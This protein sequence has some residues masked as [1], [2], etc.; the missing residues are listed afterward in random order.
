MATRD[1]DGTACSQCASDTTERL[2]ISNKA[3]A[4]GQKLHLS[5]GAQVVKDTASDVGSSVK[6]AVG[7]A[8]D[9]TTVTIPGVS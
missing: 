9:G 2:G 1:V 4:V 5:E 8:V 3:K 7:S 6:A